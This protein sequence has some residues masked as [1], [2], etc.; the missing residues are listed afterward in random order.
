MHYIVRGIESMQ[1]NYLQMMTDSLIMKKSLLEKITILNEEQRKMAES[2][3]DEENFLKVVDKKSELIDN[4][5]R[6]DDGFNSL[7][8]RVKQMLEGN[9]EKY[10][11]QIAEIQGLIRNITELAVKV[12]TQEKRNKGLI[13]RQFMLLRKDVNNTK[14]KTNKVNSYYQN[15]NKINM[16]SHFMDHKQ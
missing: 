15:M 6:L 13:E 16:E 1:D 11:S 12:E 7:F 3:F 2:G 9:R 5:V 8:G 4:I 14:D 10:S